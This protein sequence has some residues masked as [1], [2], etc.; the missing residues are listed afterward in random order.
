MSYFDSQ[1]N[2]FVKAFIASDALLY[3][4]LNIVN[5]L[6]VLYVIATVHGGTVQSATGALAV[7]LVARVIVEL[8]VGKVSSTM[9]EQGKLRLIIGGM[10]GISLSYAGFAFS[11]N[12]YMLG[13]LWILNGAGWAIGHP[14]KLALV[15]KHI[16]HEQAS[17]EWGFT[18]AINMT[19]IIITMGLGAWVVGHFSYAVLFAFAAAI[20]TGGIMP[21]V[22][23][24]SKVAVPR[25][26]LADNADA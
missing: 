19:L 16:N 25:T 5:I 7:G 20:N 21:Y 3:S 2:P 14:A 26:A 9:S 17:Q 23:Y 4:S 15:A 24:A 11:H 8:S 6:F 13:L 18:D 10:A 1:V 12:I 22:W